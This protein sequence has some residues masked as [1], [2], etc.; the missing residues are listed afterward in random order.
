MFGLTKL[1]SLVC[2]SALL[3]RRVRV[4]VCAQMCVCV[5]LLCPCLHQLSHLTT[6]KAL[7]FLVARWNSYMMDM[8]IWKGKG[9]HELSKG[10]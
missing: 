10:V 7:A 9:T 3:K 6:L 4:C 5:Y 8:M 1:S 2:V